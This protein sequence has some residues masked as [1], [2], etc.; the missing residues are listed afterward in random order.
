MTAG[1]AVPTGR[2]APS[3]TGALHLGN[4]RTA[5]LAWLHSRALGGRHLLRFEDLDT[6]RVRP[7]AYDVTR[8][9]L[10]WLGLDWDAEYLQSERLELYAEALAQLDTYPCTCT[11][12]EIQV[13]IQDSAG[14]PHGREPVYPGTCRRTPADPTRPAALRWQ[15]PDW[16]VC[17]T[18]ALSAEQLCQHLPQEVGDLVL[19]RSDGVFAYHLAVVVDDA[20]MGVTDVVRGADLWPATPRQAALS[21]AL[22]LAHPRSW[23]VPLM[24]DYQGERLAKRGGAPPLRDL[25]EGGADPGRVLAELARSLGWQVPDAVQAAELLPL[26]R[27][28]AGVTEQPL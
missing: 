5:L 14:A 23:H 12:R 19:R 25:R 10:E 13:A 3:P 17:V 22:G 18:D 28:W 8:C 21:D 20:D 27:E 6:G 24:T 15:I 2:Y 26:W 16:T 4:I 11:R 7:W 1:K 9:D